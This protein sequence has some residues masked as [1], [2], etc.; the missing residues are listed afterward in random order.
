[1]ATAEL[2]ASSSERATSHNMHT[3]QFYVN[4]E[5]LV[6]DL[7]RFFATA[8]SEGQSAV[9]V[10]T[11]AHQE[12]LARRLKGHG[13][14]PSQAAAEGRYLAFDAGELL[15]RFL[16]D[17][18]IDQFKFFE[19]VGSV[20]SRA[21]AS[22]RD[23]K[24][25]VVVFGEMV[26]LLWAEGKTEMAIQLEK[27]WNA[28]ARTYS[29]SLRCAYPMQ[30][31]SFERDAAAVAEICGQHSAVVA[32]QPSAREPSSSRESARADVRSRKLQP[33]A[34]VA[35]EW[36]DREERFREF[37]EAVQDYAIFMLDP[38]GRITSWNIGAERIKGYTRA[39][40]MGSHFSRFYPPEDVQAGKP[41]MLLEM[42]RQ[43]GRTED[44]GW[45]VRKDGT[46]FWAHVIITAIRNQA[47][48]LIGF[49]KVTRD[50]TEQKRTE[51]ALHRQEQ[52]FQ[53]FVHAVQD[54][55]MFM[56]DPD[57]YVTTWN[58]GAERIKGYKASEIIG[59]HFSCFYPPGL[60]AE[61]PKRALEIAAREG[62]FED[63]A[64]RLRKDGS[65]FWASVVITAI[66]DDSGRLIGFG[67]VTR[68]LTERML[69]QKA[70]ESS[71]EKLR[72]SE[73]ALRELSLHLLRSQDEERR[74]IGREIHDSLG[75]YLS[76]LKIKLESMNAPP[77]CAPDL[78]A[79]TDLLDTCIKEVRTVSYL[80]YP[81]ML[82]EMGLRSAVPWYLDGFSKR[83]GI[84]TALRIADDF[85]RLSRDA[86]LVLFRVLQECLTNVQRHSGSSSAD[87]RIARDGDLVTLE[88]ADSGKGLP[89]AV[90]E[91]GGRDWMGSLGVGLRG[92][93]E[94]LRQLG[95][96]LDISSNSH[97]TRVRATV[98]LQEIPS[99]AVPAQK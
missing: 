55:A 64:W 9:V 2:A 44:E 3:V 30:G 88:V 84:K 33:K 75:Q 18:E 99:A 16:V 7:G 15:S 87:I 90:L 77:E 42:A 26:A 82:E 89:A 68:D 70:L 80:L 85:G 43:F 48:E 69:A 36:H 23:E 67:K 4:D 1:M 28:L 71:Q 94:R 61:R 32:E 54:Y 40:I 19:T 50:L 46:R 63:E 76:V 96:S 74:R 79:C 98:P 37:V 65:R 14:E 25:S 21:S 45:R 51:A 56:L 20:I 53:F 97:G 52:R 86:E 13:V 8:L 38:G 95:G 59:Q 12:T 5:F 41:E 58:L 27:L 49:G 31:F 35:A 24:H 81:P 47:G 39:E 83:S 34:P 92:M 78:N 93:S 72:D 10:A 22:S 60:R 6:D 91:Q 29:F 11:K 73:R 57:G 17:G 62:R 66:R